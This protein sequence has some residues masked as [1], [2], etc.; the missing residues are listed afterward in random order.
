MLDENENEIDDFSI[1]EDEGFLQELT[2]EIWKEDFDKVGYIYIGVGDEPEGCTSRVYKDKHREFVGLDENYKL[3][4]KGVATGKRICMKKIN[5]YGRLVIIAGPN[6]SGKSTLTRKLYEHHL[7][8]DL[9]INPDD[10]AKEI[11]SSDPGSVQIAAGRK[12][13]KLRE[14]Y[15]ASG[16]SFAMETTLSGVSEISFIKKAIFQ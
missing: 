9:Y 12:A 6:G 4:V 14:S 8:P 1:T 15:L 11:N 2:E 7:L 10:I 3:I 5:S 13:V 16:K